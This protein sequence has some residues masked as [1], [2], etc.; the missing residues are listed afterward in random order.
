MTSFVG[1]TDIMQEIRLNHRSYIVNRLLGEGG[2]AYVYLVSDAN[3]PNSKSVLKRVIVKDDQSRMD[4]EKEIDIMKK[5]RDTNVVEYHDSNI[6]PYYHNNNG[7]VSPLASKRLEAWIL[8]EYCSG[9]HLLDIIRG[10]GKFRF[11]SEDCYRIGMDICKALS[12]L[13]KMNPPIAHRDM[14]LENILLSSHGLYKL[15]DFGSC[16]HGPVSVRTK[17]ERA[18]E[19]ERVEKTTTQ[20]YRAPELV[21][22]YLKP[23]INES[24]DIWSLGCIFFA[25]AH[26]IHPFQD[27]GNL[28][29]LNR[30]IRSVEVPRDLEVFHEITDRMLTSDPDC[31]PTID[32]V[33]DLLND[34]RDEKKIHQ[35]P[36]RKAS[37]IEDS[38]KERLETIRQTKLQVRARN[39]SLHNNNSITSSYNEAKKLNP[40]STAAKRLASRRGGGGGNTTN[41][42]SSSVGSNTPSTS[43]TSQASSS[44]ESSIYSPQ[45]SIFMYSPVKSEASTSTSQENESIYPLSDV[46]GDFDA[47]SLNE[48]PVSTNTTTNQ[49]RLRRPS[50]SSDG[51]DFT[52]NKQDNVTN[53]NSLFGEDPFANNSSTIQSH[54]NVGATQM[55][56]KNA[57]NVNT[58][59][60]AFDPFA[61]D[62]FPS[63]DNTSND[64][65]PINQTTIQTDFTAAPTIQQSAFFNN[66][67]NEKKDNSFDPF[68]GMTNLSGMPSN[69]LQGPSSMLNPQPYPMG[70]KM[71]PDNMNGPNINTS[72]P[73]YN[74]GVNMMSQ[75]PNVNNVPFYPNT[76]NTQINSGMPFQSSNTNSDSR[77]DGG[78]E[79]KNHAFG[80]I[81]PF[82]QYNKGPAF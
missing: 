64:N 77:I 31:R 34:M 72:M 9:G 29:I 11:E 62:I 42:L 76:H 8:M 53:I 17:E 61:G 81:D 65:K 68:R 48:V 3:M 80:D 51:F 14:K 70:L 21:N 4:I 36:P 75:M 2:S 73:N 22:L 60:I 15:C 26:L 25:V 47:F 55:N 37:K 41:I 56:Q 12:V 40:S 78:N 19:E 71:V 44:V 30:N 82:G 79:S 16:V 69:G 63:F 27:L 35:L 54:S 66:Q 52:N 32:E 74:N 1:A 58:S 50:G 57:T 45:D 43:V 59:T 46:I 67:V 5:L 33:M 18:I 6:R 39:S 24:V 20:M 49:S 23:E 28:G 38:E 10:R 13:H 7:S